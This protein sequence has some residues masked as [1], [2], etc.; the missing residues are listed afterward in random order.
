MPKQGLVAVCVRY[1]HVEV[2]KERAIGFMN[3]LDL[4]AAVIS[5][6]ILQLLEPLELDPLLCVGLCFNGAAVMP[7]N[8]GCVHVILK[9]TF[10]NAIYVNC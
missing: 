4:T 1:F 2:I 5:E 9:R 10:P 6:N 8:R 7:G 3:T